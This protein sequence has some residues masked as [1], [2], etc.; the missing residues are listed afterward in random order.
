M[1]SDSKTAQTSKEK[2]LAIHQDA[3]CQVANTLVGQGPLRQ[4]YQI[5]RLDGRQAIS[6]SCDTEAEAWDSAAS[7][8][9]LNTESPGGSHSSPRDVFTGVLHSSA[10]T[11]GEY[12]CECGLVRGHACSH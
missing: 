6:S 11:I 10:Q 8:M 7:H 3:T 12:L 4:T 9:H 5:F 2:V 1:T